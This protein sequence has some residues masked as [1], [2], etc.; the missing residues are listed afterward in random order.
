MKKRCLVSFVLSLLLLV[1]LLAG[2]AGNPPATGGANG[3]AAGMDIQ[4][5]ARGSDGAAASGS[6]S[7]S[8][9]RDGAAASGSQPGSGGSAVSDAS[10][11]QHGAGEPNPAANAG[12]RHT[13]GGN[14]ASQG[15]GEQAAGTPGRPGDKQTTYPIAV[16]DGAGRAVTIQAEPTRVISVAP[17]NTELMFALGKGGLLVGRSD[18]DDYPPEAGEIESIGGFYPPDYEKII[19]LE[20]DLILLTG[21]SVEARERLENAYGLT[22]LVLDPANFAE[23][24]DGI[25]MLGR[26]VNAQ[27][28]AERLVAEMQREVRAIEEKAATAA[29]RPVVFYEVWY[30]PIIT[31]GPGSFIDDMIRIAGGTN[32]AAFAGE[33]WPAISL[34]ELVAADPDIIVARSEGAAQEARQRAGWESITAVREGRVLGLPDENIVVRPGPRLIQGLRWFARHIHPELFGR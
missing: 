20:P 21:G 16:T 31:A 26:V 32:A 5:G 15:S 19:A 7:G 34:E 8:G 33:P 6:Q 9:G 12:S 10:G 27:E 4:P 1:G 30:D 11:S 3:A 14:A 17:S 25:L 23:L 18:W 22:T 24:Y 29:T 28:A 2:C 13:A